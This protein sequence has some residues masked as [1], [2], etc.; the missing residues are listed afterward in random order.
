MAARTGRPPAK[1]TAAK[2]CAAVAHVQEIAGNAVM[3]ISLMK[4]RKSEERTAL[5]ERF[6]PGAKAWTGEG[7]KGWFRAPRTLPHLLGLLRSKALSG[8]QDPSSAYL[9]LWARHLDSG[10][11]EIT[12]EKELAYEAGYVGN[13]ALRTWQER[14]RLLVSLGFIK[15]QKSGNEPYR[16]V[17]MVDP[18][19]VIAGLVKRKLVDPGWAATYDAR[20][21]ATKEAPPAEPQE[22][23]AEKVVQMPGTA[24]TK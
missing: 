6:W 18:A 21:I 1:E 23:P 14:M 10:I 4:N 3:R 2:R 24:K 9:V 20:R 13:R 11:V 5:R 22:T 15:A 7:T 16:Y 17:L 19:V 12:N 8:R